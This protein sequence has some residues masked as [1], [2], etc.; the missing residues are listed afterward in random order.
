M[1][2]ATKMTIKW[3]KPAVKTV[4]FQ[5]LSSTVRAAACSTFFS[6]CKNNFR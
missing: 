5:Q 3:M 1:K 6:L 4:S 2:Q